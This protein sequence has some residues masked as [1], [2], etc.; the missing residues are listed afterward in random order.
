ML[1]VTRY[2]MWDVS[3][4][5]LPMTP[6]RYRLGRT[7]TSSDK[8]GRPEPAQLHG[9]DCR[10]TLTLRRDLGHKR[11]LAQTPDKARTWL[12]ASAG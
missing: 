1:A 4:G 3:S 10:Q 6:F 7:R 5:I 11:G 12:T 9:G 2:R 8:L